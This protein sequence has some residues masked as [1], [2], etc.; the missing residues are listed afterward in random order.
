MPLPIP[1]SLIAE[2]RGN[3][4]DIGW[5]QTQR[6]ST[7]DD[8]ARA[9]WVLALWAI[10]TARVMS[11][12]ITDWEQALGQLSQSRYR[13]VRLAAQHLRQCGYLT[14]PPA[15]V[16]PQTER[17]AQLAADSTTPTQQP[18]AAAA[19]LG[20]TH[21]TSPTSLTSVAREAKWLKVDAAATYK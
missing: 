1:A 17:G 10:G 15:T 2:T 12:L 3:A 20:A 11:A 9:E 21:Q 18:P 7:E 16:T 19:R 13:A 14:T 5:W 6:L 4:D 8:L